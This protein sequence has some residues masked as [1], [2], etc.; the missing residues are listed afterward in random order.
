MAFSLD[1]IFTTRTVLPKNTG[2][3]EIEPPEP[4]RPYVRCFWT[5][6]GKF[7]HPVRIIPD[8]C[9]DIIF[10][11]SN[12]GAG[13]AETS[14]DSFVTENIGSLFGIR[15]YTWAVSRF[16]HIN[17]AYLFDFG[18]KPEDIFANFTLLYDAIMYAESTEQR[19]SVA[20]DYLLRSLDERNDSDVMNGLYEII[21]NNGNISVADLSDGLAVSKRTLERK[22]M[23]DIGI[24]P[25]TMSELI[26]Y[27][28]LW[29]ECVNRDFD[30]FD[31][32]DKFG[33]YDQAHMC[34]DFKRYHGI[35]L[36]E[37]RQEFIKLS[38]IY[39]TFS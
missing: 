32:I 38:Q 17:A 28:L 23:R 39:N 11:I 16:A 21:C 10:D 4:L 13:F 6:N 36:N 29:Q 34:N 27:Q 31:A 5:F 3:V 20:S 18:L 12:Y 14:F 8:C 1:K 7:A 9:A 37:A 2:V 15:F 25:K 35:G 24:S 30:V 22:F 19:V 26:R 33:Y